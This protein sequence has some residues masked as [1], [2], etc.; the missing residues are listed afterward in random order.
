[1]EEGQ[2]LEDMY[3][4]AENYNKFFL[5][6]L[7]EYEHSKELEGWEYLG[8]DK[9]EEIEVPPN[10]IDKLSTKG[11]KSLLTYD[12]LLDIVF[13]NEGKDCHSSSEFEPFNDYMEIIKDNII[14]GSFYSLFCMCEDDER[15]LSNGRFEFYESYLSAYND[16]PEEIKKEIQSDAFKAPLKRLEETEEA[17]ARGEFKEEEDLGKYKSINVE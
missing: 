15:E 17:L 16:T 5:K 12:N 10:E 2:I 7:R 1:M 14:S 3:N 6:P 4:I 8:K 9:V 13:H 11:S